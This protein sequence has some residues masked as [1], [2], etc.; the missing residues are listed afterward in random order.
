M[1]FVMNHAACAGSLEKP[2]DQ[3]SSALPL[4]YRCPLHS[5]QVCG[6]TKRVSWSMKSYYSQP[7]AVDFIKSQNTGCQKTL[8][9]EAICL[10]QHATS[11]TLR[12]EIAEEK[13]GVEKHFLKFSWFYSV[14]W[15]VSMVI[16][17]SDP[18]KYIYRRID[19]C[20]IWLLWLDNQRIEPVTFDQWSMYCQ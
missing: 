4:C 20:D 10:V 15:G 13:L 18:L 19:K 7:L 6:K 5:P 14:R 2:V 16:E 17:N 12:A 1:N 9:P 8:G 11:T 3:Q